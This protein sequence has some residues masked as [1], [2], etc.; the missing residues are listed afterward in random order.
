MDKKSAK[1]FLTNNSSFICI[2]MMRT[3][4]DISIPVLIVLLLSSVPWL[5]KCSRSS[6]DSNLRSVAEATRVPSQSLSLLQKSEMFPKCLFAVK[7]S[8]M[9]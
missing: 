4:K 5:C 1:L 9:K 8:K 7:W 6:I 3:W 2:I